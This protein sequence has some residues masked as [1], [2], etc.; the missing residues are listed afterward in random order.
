MLWVA[1]PWQVAFDGHDAVGRLDVLDREGTGSLHFAV[2]VHGAS[3]ALADAA[4]VFRTGQAA[5]LTNGPEQWRVAVDRQIDA[6]T[7]DIQSCHWRKVPPECTP[8]A[9]YGGVLL[10]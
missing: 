9:F 1:S 6:F 5:L 8:L 3:P 4:T 2:D 10:S 7:V